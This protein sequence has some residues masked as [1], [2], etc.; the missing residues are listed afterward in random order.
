MVAKRYNEKH[1][2]V[3]YETDVTKNM[4]I[5][6][7][8]DLM[9][10][11]SENQSEQLGIGTDKVNGLGYGWVITQHVLEIER[12]PKVNEEVKIWTE[13]DSY[14]KYFC[15]REFGIDDLDDNP[16]VRMHTIFVLMDFKNRKISQIVP[17][18]IIPFGANET[19]KV[20]RY[21]NVKKIKEIDNHKKYQVRFMD[22]DS[23]HHVNNVHYFDWMLDTLDYDFLSKHTLKKI[24]IQYKQEITYG[25]IVTSN[26]QIINSNDTITTLH[27]VK[28]NDKASCLAECEWI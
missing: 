11:A 6:M 17:E 16:L 8:V 22:I 10:L 24:N 12:L 13:A 2:V 15:Y 1:R 27:E 5:G 3:F 19:P 26:V 14:N 23:N 25:D 9:M 28:N 18:L 4:N 20:K 21:K 7:L